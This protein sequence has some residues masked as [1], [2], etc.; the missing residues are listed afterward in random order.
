[1][2]AKREHGR[3]KAE[4]KEFLMSSMKIW[5]TAKAV[6]Q[7]TTHTCGFTDRQPG[8]KVKL[9]GRPVETSESSGGKF[10]NLYLD[11]TD[12]AIDMPRFVRGQVRVITFTSSYHEGFRPEGMYIHKGAK[13]KVQTVVNVQSPNFGNNA[14]TSSIERRQEISISA[15]SIKALQEIYTLI[16][17]GNLQPT[18]KWS[19]GGQSGVSFAEI[20]HNSF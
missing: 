15:K 13:A 12:P 9:Y 20:D 2:L 8:E 1:M 6:A 16:R 17:Q 19:D 10:I 4:Y 5:L 7:P 18:E 11:P 14:D 3:P